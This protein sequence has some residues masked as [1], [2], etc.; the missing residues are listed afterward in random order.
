MLQGQSRGGKYVHAIS[1]PQAFQQLYSEITSP[2]HSKPV[3]K[4]GDRT[5]H[6]VLPC[7]GFSVPE[8]HLRRWWECE[9]SPVPTGFRGG[10]ASSPQMVTNR[11]VSAGMS[12]RT[13]LTDVPKALRHAL[14]LVV[15]KAGLNAAKSP[16]LARREVEAA[17]ESVFGAA[18]LARFVGLSPTAQEREAVHITLLVIGD[19]PHRCSLLGLL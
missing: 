4:P 16:G 19:P 13:A 10:A 18:G 7:Y 5:R 17:L 15:I 9:T 6:E 11:M 12:S 8:S 2:I 3:E 1:C 14:D